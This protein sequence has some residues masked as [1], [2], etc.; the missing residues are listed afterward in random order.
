[1][2]HRQFEHAIRDLNNRDG[3]TN[4]VQAGGQ[5]DLGADI[6]VRGAHSEPARASAPG[7]L[8]SHPRAPLPSPSQRGDRGAA[9]VESSG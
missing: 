3:C 6:A 9:S 4:A 2:S 1:M 5:D 8:T 7:A